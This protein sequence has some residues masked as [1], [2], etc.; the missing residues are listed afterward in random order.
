MAQD[1]PPSRHGELA[2]TITRVYPNDGNLVGRRDIVARRKV[3]T[4]DPHGPEQA[5]VGVSGNEI[6]VSATPV[7]AIVKITSDHMLLPPV[8]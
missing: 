2:V 7:V 5:G 3:R 1:Q 8:V 4:W 6:I